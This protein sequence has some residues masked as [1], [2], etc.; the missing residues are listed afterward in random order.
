MG[1]GGVAVLIVAALVFA[2]LGFVFGQVVQAANSNPGTLVTETYV[3]KYVGEI[4]AEM[5]SRIDELEMLILD[6]SGGAPVTSVIPEPQPNNPDNLTV[7]NPITTSPAPTSVKIKSNGVNVR[8][9]ASATASI[10]GSVATNTVLTYIGQ[11]NDSEGRAWYNV[12]LAN[13]T[14]GWVA[15]WLCYEPE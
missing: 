13:G 15:G 4:I 11:K 14:E 6:L 9:D 1:K 10:V 3:Q 2:A 7:P 8:S 5:Q 12:R